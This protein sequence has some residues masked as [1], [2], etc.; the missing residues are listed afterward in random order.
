MNLQVCGCQSFS[1]VQFSVVTGADN[2]LLLQDID[3]KNRFETVNKPQKSMP[4]IF[5]INTVLDEFNSSP[6]TKFCDINMQFK[7]M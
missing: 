1:P 7:P 4:E 5:R 6:H 2:P 3:K